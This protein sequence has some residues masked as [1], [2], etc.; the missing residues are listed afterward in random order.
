VLIAN[1]PVGAAHDP[2]ERSIEQ[3]TR[4]EP[5]RPDEPHALADTV[6]EPRRD[7]IELRY[8]DD[9]IPAPVS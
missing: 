4:D 5:E 8:T 3:E 9:D 1:G 2:E 6:E 7:A